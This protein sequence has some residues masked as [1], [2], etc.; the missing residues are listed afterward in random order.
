LLS[1]HA[2]SVCII[3]STALSNPIPDRDY[4]VINNMTISELD[5]TCVLVVLRSQ[6]K[7][8]TLS[9]VCVIS[10][11]AAIDYLGSMPLPSMCPRL[12]ISSMQSL[13]LALTNSHHAYRYCT[14]LVTMDTHKHRVR[15]INTPIFTI[16]WGTGQPSILMW[17]WFTNTLIS[18]IRCIHHTATLQQ[19]I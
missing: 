11:I 4:R 18:I 16:W 2:Q 5:E 13:S 10:N 8:L 3:A 1:Q 12:E 15:Y 19:L 17:G 7:Y 14:R 6:T 9:L